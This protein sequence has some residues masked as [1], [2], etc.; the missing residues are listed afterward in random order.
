MVRSE[1]NLGHFQNALSEDQQ[2]VILQIQD[3]NFHLVLLVVLCCLFPKSLG[4]GP[5]VQSQAK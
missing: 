5:T 2:R 3:S 4:P 1:W